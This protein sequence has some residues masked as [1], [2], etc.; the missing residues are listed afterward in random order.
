MGAFLTYHF[1]N[2]FGIVNT[3]QVCVDLVLWIRRRVSNLMMLGVHVQ[4]AAACGITSKGPWRSARTPGASF[5]ILSET[6]CTD[7]H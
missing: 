2:Y 4:A 5:I 3:Y 1:F 7:P 6:P